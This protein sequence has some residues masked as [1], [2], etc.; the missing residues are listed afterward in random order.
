MSTTPQA[1][2]AGT[3]APRG[4]MCVQSSPKQLW[5]L[6][7]VAEMA[8]FTLTSQALAA[9]DAVGHC[10]SVRSVQFVALML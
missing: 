3:T 7:V 2:G 4:L 10:D 1:A 6:G 8:N 9:L 5:W